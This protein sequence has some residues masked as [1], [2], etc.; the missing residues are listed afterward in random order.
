MRIDFG[1]RKILTNVPGLMPRATPYITIAKAIFSKSIPDLLKL[2][3]TGSRFSSCSYMVIK[4]PP[5]TPPKEGN[6]NP[7]EGL[8]V[9]FSKKVCTMCNS[10]ST[11]TV[12][13]LFGRGLGEAPLQ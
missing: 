8:G 3:F 2:I 11:M 13:P 5:L 10:F 9:G 1:W 4:R 12:S 6:S 7:G